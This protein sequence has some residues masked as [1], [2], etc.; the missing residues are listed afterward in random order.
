MSMM[1]Q[2]EREATRTILD[3]IKGREEWINV[4]NTMKAKI[5]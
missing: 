5:E 2:G 3:Q 4:I 1:E